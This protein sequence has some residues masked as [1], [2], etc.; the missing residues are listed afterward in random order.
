M[1]CWEAS[2]GSEAL[3]K[4]YISSNDVRKCPNKKCP[5]L[6]Q[7]N[8]GCNKVFCAMCKMSI[9]WKC[10]KHFPEQQLAYNHLNAQHGG[11]FDN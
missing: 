11:Y 3:F 10:M 7:K 1:T 9:C 4:M 2:V 8:G 5:A 6:I